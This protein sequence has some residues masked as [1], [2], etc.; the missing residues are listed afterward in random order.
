M[1]RRF[2]FLTILM[3]S[4]FLFANTAPTVTQV[5][6]NQRTDG[7]GVVDIAY[8]L[9]DADNDKCTISVVVSNDGGSTFTIVPSSGALSGALTNVSPGRRTITWSSKMDLPG[10]FGS[11]YR[12]K[13]T[14]DDGQGPSGM[15]WVYINDPGVSG[16]EP[17]NGYM[18]KYETTNAQFAQ[19]L[20][21]A[22]ASNDITVSGNYVV[23][24]SGS[25]SGSD[26]VG[27]NY[28]NLAGSGFTYDGATNGGA[29]RINW[30]GSSFTVDAGFENHPV[31]YVSWY[32]SMAFAS[33]YGWR[34]PTEWEWQ[35]VADYNG[36]YTY[37]CGT[38]INNS[39][40]NY[41]NSVHPHGT[42]TVGAFGTYGYGMADMA[43]NVWEWTS[44]L[45][46]P[47]DSYRIIRGGS[48][49]NNDNLCTVS[50]RD[51]TDPYKSN[52]YYG[53][54]VCR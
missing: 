43:G 16:H 38:T 54:R 47:G 50:F 41:Y 40:A 2:S 3:C 10:V 23:G 36:S 9:A 4:P 22:K 29:A 52:D 49:S 35:A 48:W 26:F 53:F 28:Y 14:A 15:E 19:Y 13:L 39:I 42:T 25:N 11:N 18:S 7:S 24:S 20:N 45:W 30:T 1:F 8:T 37:G 34:L 21:A 12:I 44:S 31:T 5:T 6:A 33:Y 46:D 17:F 32:G 27:Q 51:Y